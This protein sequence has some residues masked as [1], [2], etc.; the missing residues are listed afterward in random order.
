[1]KNK[2]FSGLIALMMIFAAVSFTSC[3]KNEVVSDNVVEMAFKIHN[4]SQNAS[5]KNG[6]DEGLPECNDQATPSY[7]ITT[8]GGTLYTIP[9]LSSFDPTLTQTIKFNLG[10]LEEEDL[11]ITT[12]EVYDAADN[13]IWLAPLNGS[14][15]SG[16]LSNPLDLT[17][18]VEAFKKAQIDID[19]L[20]WVPAEYENFGYNWLAFHKYKVYE[21]CFFGDVCTK[22]YEDWNSETHDFAA[23]FTVNIFE[24][25]PD[26]ELGN[27]V[28]IIGEG[29]NTN[30]HWEVIDD[31]L[32]VEYI[33]N[34]EDDITDFTA[35]ISLNAP[36][37][38]LIELGSTQV[39]GGVLVDSGTDGVFDFLAGG[40]DCM[41]GQEYDALYPLTWMPMPEVVEFKLGHNAASTTS[42]FRLD[43]INVVTGAQT[44]EFT[45]GTN[46][47]AWCAK[48]DWDITVGHTY[49]ARVHPYYNAPAIFAAVSDIQ[50]RALNYLANVN[51]PAAVAAGSHS[52]I[53]TIQD[54]IWAILGQLASPPPAALLVK[55]EAIAA[56][57]ANYVP[58]IGGHIIVLVEPY[59]NLSQTSKMVEEG[60]FQ[61]A[62]VRVD[63]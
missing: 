43:N 2:L 16:W 30:V 5:F 55:N 15:Y 63:P 47:N 45:N 8:I 32:C 19:V 21:I 31:V 24:T 11:V 54:A 36:D 35:V 25:L 50:W 13:L 29:A 53:V 60:Q 39:I 18:T 49:R 28:T 4:P 3:E 12:F 40:S 10:Q 58:P 42:Y 38:T 41:Y 46:L 48:K 62:M 14:I 37:G 7:V 33:D 52:K 20:C 44:V 22:F 61:V 57:I 17:F 23:P 59:L 26:G 56:A 6:G 9:V 51:I 27:E 1:M 34:L